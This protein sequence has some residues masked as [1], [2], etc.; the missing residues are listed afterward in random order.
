VEYLRVDLGSEEHIL[1]G[2][3]NKV[4]LALDILRVGVHYKW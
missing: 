2:V 3:T 4:D 1:Q